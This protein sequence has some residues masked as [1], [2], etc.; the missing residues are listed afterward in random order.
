MRFRI[1]CLV[2]LCSALATLAQAQPRT[3]TVEVRSSREDTEGSE[4]AFHLKERFR[5]NPLFK[6]AATGE[7]SGFQVLVTGISIGTS[8]SVAYS[9]VLTNTDLAAAIKDPKTKQRYYSSS[10]V[11]YCSR[12]ALERCAGAIYTTFGATIEEESDQMNAIL[13]DALDAMK[14]R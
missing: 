6:V 3:I 1:F 7:S 12:Q 2:G 4:I 8:G 13:R 14:K 11:G 10:T 5:Q 9:V